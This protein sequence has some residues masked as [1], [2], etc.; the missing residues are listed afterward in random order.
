MES[1]IYDLPALGREQSWSRSYVG[2][3]PGC[4]LPVAVRLGMSPMTE[5]P[6]PLR[7]GNEHTLALES[8][9]G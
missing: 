3:D 2:L 5:P 8:R 6:L 7:N 9:Q 1:V 4:H